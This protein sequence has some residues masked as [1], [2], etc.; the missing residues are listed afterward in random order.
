M[1]TISKTDLPLILVVDDDSAMRLLLVQVLKQEG[2]QVVEASNGEQALDAFTRLKP[3]IVLLD[4]VMPVMDG[5]T[6]CSKLRNLT[7]DDGTPVLMIT[8]LEEQ[9]S[10]DQAFEVGATDYITKPIHWAVLRQRV[11]RLTQAR[12]AT[13]DLRQQ[14]E[15]EQLMGTVAQRIRSSLNLE[16]VLN[17]TVAEVRQF[18]QVDRVLIYQFVPE[19]SGVVVV[20]S[21]EKPWPSTLGQTVAGLCFPQNCIQLHRQNQVQATK[22]ICA[23]RFDSGY[24][25]F[26]AKFQVKAN[27]VVPIL[28]EEEPWGLLIVHHCAT[29]RQWQ[30]LEVNLLQQLA[31]QVAIA[32]RQSQLY[33]KVQQLNTGLEQQVQHRTLQL[34]KALEFEATLKRVTDKV[35]DSLDENQ[36]LQTAVRELALALNVDCCDT[37]LYNLI[38]ATSTISCQYTNSLSS[39]QGLVTRMADYPEIYSQL[40]QGQFVQFCKT[41]YSPTHKQVTALACPIFDNQG[42]LGDLWLFKPKDCTFDE[43]ETRLIQ[44]VA[45]QCAIAIRQA[46]LYET[47]QIQVR[48][49]KKLNQLKNDFLSTVSHELRTPVTIIKTAL[50]MLE[51][52]IDREYKSFSG[53]AKPT[54][55]CGPAARYF[56]ILSNECEREIKLINDLLR[57]QELNAGTRSLEHAVID[58]Q[59]WLPRVVEPFFRRA[60][61]QNQRLQLNLSPN[62]SPLLSDSFGLERI[63]TELLNNACK[64][65]PPEET[66]IVAACTEGGVTKL[67]VSNSGVQLS[68]QE[69]SCIFDQFYRIP[70]EEPGKHGGTGLGL[71]LVQK[72]VASLGGSIDA[73]ST[74][75]CTCFRI[76]LPLIALTT[77]SNGTAAL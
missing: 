53:M 26:L 22:N 41:F 74:T 13:K 76:E 48:E 77:R 44:Q 42:T 71:A 72:L 63:L 9:E 12:R 61:S 33:Q 5:F 55:E 54:V 4:A 1:N 17:T 18:L 32:I 8:S 75:E 50:Q 19:Q 23:E 36:I 43:Q 6:C 11:R 64:Y 49:L 34:Q 30:P 60:Q 24:P 70:C 62:L 46:R 37:G 68:Q 69:L 27:L 56:E 67:S 58:L 21:V 29:N 73:E 20:E 59:D 2:Y 38:E 28:Q 7:D 15:R 14:A 45:N 51:I 40:L 65:T 3:D 35:R 16:E 25:D 57:L 31:T 10:V 66:I 52:T 47:A 39:S